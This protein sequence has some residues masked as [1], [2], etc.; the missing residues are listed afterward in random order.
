MR[1]LV[2][3]GTGMVGSSFAEEKSSH[4]LILVGSKQYDLRSWHDT[5]LMMMNI[6]PDVV[7]HLA[8]RVGGVKGNTD[9]VADFFSEN[10]NMNTN[11]L[12][13]S[14][15]FGVKKVV[16]LLSTCVYPDKVNYPLTEDQVHNG[17]PHLSNFGYAYSKRML[18]VQS[19]A[20]RQQYGCNFICAIPN[21]LYGPHDNFDLENGHVIPAIIRKIWEAKQ[22]GVAPIFWSDGSALREFTYA[23]D[24]S[25][26]LLHLL[27]EYNDPEPVNI[28]IAE[29]RSIASVVDLVCK[30]LEYNGLV[31]WDESKPAGQYRKPSSNGKLIS[32]GWD[33]SSY[34]AFEIGL[35]KT[36]DWFIENYPN[37]RGME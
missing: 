13:A 20:L 17:P 23:P 30:N 28:G 29:E 26:I 6:I 18:D 10:I 2:T 35:K 19:K 32:T 9:F 14:K 7:I 4:E 27:N 8:A 33:P 15:E 22:T 25:R 11:V 36:C 21:N 24:L 31:S 1:V 37:V 3:G 12:Q 5:Q 34:T 16:S